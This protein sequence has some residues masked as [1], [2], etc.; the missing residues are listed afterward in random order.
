MDETLAF[1]DL[2][3][4]VELKIGLRRARAFAGAE[5]LLRA[6]VV[7]GAQER[8]TNRLLDAGTRSEERRVGKECRL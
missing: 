1:Q 6:A 7:A 8:V 3:Q 2:D 5:F 4:S